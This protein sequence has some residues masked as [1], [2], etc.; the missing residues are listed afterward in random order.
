MYT[1]KNQDESKNSCCTFSRY[2][3]GTMKAN[4]NVDDYVYVCRY[5]VG[6]IYGQGHAY[7]CVC[8]SV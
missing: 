2:L 6:V 4:N 5:Y 1:G 7:V 8:V 3:V